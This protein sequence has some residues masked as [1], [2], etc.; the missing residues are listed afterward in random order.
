MEGVCR[1]VYIRTACGTKFFRRQHFLDIHVRVYSS[2]REMCCDEVHFRL[3]LHH[4]N[5]DGRVSWMIFDKLFEYLSDEINGTSPPLSTYEWGKEVC[6]LAPAGP[7]VWSLADVGKLERTPTAEPPMN[8]QASLN[9]VS[10]S[11]IKA[12]G[13][14]LRIF[15]YHSRIKHV[16]PTRSLRKQT[17]SVVSS[18][19][20]TRQLSYTQ[21]AKPMEG[22]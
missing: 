20:V 21:R 12:K 7:I 13:F 11:I 22:R 15:R 3:S 17:S 14:Q 19:P 10:I 18:F 1:Q 2:L 16:S 8:S 4:G 5:A 9:I 6:R